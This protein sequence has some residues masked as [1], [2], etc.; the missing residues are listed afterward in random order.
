[1]TGCG[2]ERA[3][4]RLTLSISGEFLNPPNEAYKA[5][6]PMKN[7]REKE[8]LILAIPHWKLRAWV[9]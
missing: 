6:V 1:V 3:S 8:E 9:A 5:D 7:N 2:Q 4:Q